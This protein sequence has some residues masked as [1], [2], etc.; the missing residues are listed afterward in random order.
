M[1]ILYNN[2]K[3]V[4]PGRSTEVFQVGMAMKIS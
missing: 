2:Y 1:V 4:F 3:G